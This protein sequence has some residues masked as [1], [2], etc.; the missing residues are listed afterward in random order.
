[1]N[2]FRDTE[3]H[4]VYIFV[5]FLYRNVFSAI[6]SVW[7]NDTIDVINVKPSFLGMARV[8]RY[9]GKGRYYLTG[10]SLKSTAGDQFGSVVVLTGLR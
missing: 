4:L 5:T 1:M 2:S 8:R 7:N 10:L 3:T 9:N 6:N